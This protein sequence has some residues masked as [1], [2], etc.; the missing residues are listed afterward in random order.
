[1][2]LLACLDTIAGLPYM[3]DELDEEG[4]VEGDEEHLTGA[5]AIGESNHYLNYEMHNTLGEEKLHEYWASSGASDH[6]IAYDLGGDCSVTT[7]NIMHRGDSQAPKTCT[8]QF[9]AAANGPWEDAFHFDTARK[10]DLQSFPIPA[11]HHAR[12]WRLFMHDSHYH[13]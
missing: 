6:W 11:E 2:T 8:L 1:V 10:S 7:F 5:I 9:A 13:T 3:L 4:A 12:Y